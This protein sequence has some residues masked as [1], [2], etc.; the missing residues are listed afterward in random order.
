VP[1]VAI[2]R[3][4]AELRDHQPLNQ[5]TGAVHGAAY[6]DVQGRIV[7]AR[8]DIGRHNALDKLLGAMVRGGHHPGEGFVLLTSRCSFEMVQKA[9]TCGVAVLV[10]ISAPTSLALRLAEE[11]GVTVVALARADSMIAHTHAHRLG[12]GSAGDG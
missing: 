12:L 8:E 1:P 5:R 2:R 4:L 7:L 6:V 10:A 3:A 11:T 9:A